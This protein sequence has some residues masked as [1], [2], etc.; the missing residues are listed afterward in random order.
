[1]I[2]LPDISVSYTFH[3]QFETLCAKTQ[4]QR[5]LEDLYI[6]IFKPGLCPILLWLLQLHG[7]L[8]TLYQVK[9]ICKRSALQNKLPGVLITEI[10]T[11]M[12]AIFPP[13][14]E[15]WRILIHPV[16]GR[17]AYRGEETKTDVIN[18]DMCNQQSC[19]NLWC[20]HV[21]GAEVDINHQRGCSVD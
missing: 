9:R 5:A 8:C 7:Q 10:N 18:T 11:E 1:M 12:S 15:N 17:P 13:P 19:N 20:T 14:L 2:T 3:S 4:W 6:S 21:S 16:S